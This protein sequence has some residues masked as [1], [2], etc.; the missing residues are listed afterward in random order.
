LVRRATFLKF[1]TWIG[2]IAISLAAMDAHA[3]WNDQWTLR[4][5]ITLDASPAGADIKES[6]S[7]VPVLIRLHTGNHLFPAGKDNGDD[8]RFI[9][10]DDKTPL[11]YHIEK[12][13]PIEEMALVWVKAPAVAGGNSQNHIWLYYGNRDAAAAQE[14]GATYDP[15]L[16]AV[17]HLND[18]E[19]NP[20]DAT[21]NQN[22]AVR[23]SGG[24]GLPGVIA[25]GIALNGGGDQ[26]AVAFT[27]SLNFQNGFTFSAWIRIAA[28]QQEAWLAVQQ[29]TDSRYDNR[30]VVGIDGRRLFVSV[31]KFGG[32]KA[33][34]DQAGELSIGTWHHVAVTVEPNKQVVVYLDGVETGKT[35]L[36][37]APAALKSEILIGNSKA[38]DRGLVAELD[39]ITFSNTARPAGWVKAL[40]ASQGPDAKMVIASGDEKG[41]GGGLPIFYLVTIVKNISLDG[42][43][44]IGLLVLLMIASWL[45]FFSKTV[46]LMLTQ[47]ENKKFAQVFANPDWL[48]IDAQA[49]VLQNSTL[50]RIFSAGKQELVNCI[51]SNR[52]SRVI[53]VGGGNPHPKEKRRVLTPLGL[54]A[55]KNAVE[56]GYIEETR[57]LNAWLVVMTLAVA[58]GPFLGLLGTVWGVMNTFAAMAEAGEANLAAIAPGIASALAT[59]VVGLIVAIPALFSY[60]FLTAR[61]K[62]IMAELAVFV[63]RFTNRVEEHYGG[64]R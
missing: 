30:W 43:I 59:T 34:I 49:D 62:E 7:N 46:F 2:A 56:A 22:H 52:L 42:W 17:F 15:N 3:W 61:I 21:A 40:F 23:F 11:K 64:S 19:G 60:N 12:Y 6:L 45:V 63:D 33:A 25:N 4:K 9:G 14:P 13:D 48:S 1:M 24:Q 37:F 20:K 18:L 5:K 29:D 47:S 53:E 41:G 35:A 55:I 8:I 57:R 39:E 31:I 36:P 54:S 10:P 32:D 50:Y 44:I 28:P 58:G 26:L 16:A 38:G 51:K 27:E